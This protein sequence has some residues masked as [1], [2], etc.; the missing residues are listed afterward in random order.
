MIAGQYAF[1]AVAEQAVGDGEVAAFQTDA[2]AIAVG[3][4]D[5]LEDDAVDRGGAAA[6]DQRALP[7]ARHAVEDRGARRR[8]AD[9]D[10][11]PLL[12]RALAIGAGRDDDRA[13]AIADRL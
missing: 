3:H 10:V 12:H 6:K 7:F 13:P 5:I 4:A 2:R 8:G 11:A 1:L 9:G